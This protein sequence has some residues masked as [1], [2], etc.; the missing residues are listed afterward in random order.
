MRRSERIIHAVRIPRYLP[1]G[2]VTTA[3][4]MF[5]M[6]FFLPATDIVEMDNTPPGTA[7]TGWQAFTTSLAVFGQPLTFLLILKMPRMLL[8]LAFPFINLMMLLAPVAALAWEEAWILSGWFMLCGFVPWL[9]PKAIAGNL[10]AGFYFWDV[11]FFVMSAGCVLASIACKQAYET[12]IQRL[13][14]S[15]A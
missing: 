7:L 15:A 5:M 14:K 8:L 13:R 3:W 4:L 12:E 2:V 6:S 10:F 9:L 11:S 1:V